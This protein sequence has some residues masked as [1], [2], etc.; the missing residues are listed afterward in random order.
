MERAAAVVGCRP[1]TMAA[2]LVTARPDDS[3]GIARHAVE[4]ELRACHEMFGL[5]FVAFR[6]HNVYG[7]RQGARAQVSLA[8]GLAHTASWVRRHG[9]RWTPAFEGIE[10]E[11]NLP[12][13]W[14]ER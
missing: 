6:P 7:P 12:P 5:D 2:V 4:L 3:Y 1:D 9:A 14:L 13:V 10:I 8:D 11:K